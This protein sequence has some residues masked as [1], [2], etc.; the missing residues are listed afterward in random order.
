[1]GDQREEGPEGKDTQEKGKARG[2]R[3]EY[4]YCSYCRHSIL[5]VNC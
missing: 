2:G 4:F 5:L 1:M 3:T